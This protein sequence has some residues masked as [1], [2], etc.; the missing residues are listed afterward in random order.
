[1]SAVVYQFE[2]Q[3]P[4]AADTDPL[5]ILDIGS[6][7]VRLVV[8][9]GGNRVPT[10]L[11]NEKSLCGL[12]RGLASTGA[13][14]EPGIE[15]ALRALRRFRTLT[16]AMNVRVIYPVATAAVR[17]A[18]NGPDFLAAAEEILEVPVRLVSG[19][20]EAE[21]AALGV[22]SGIPDAEGVIG[23]LGGGS[24]ELLDV[25][26]GQLAD[27]IT[28]ELG[29]LRLMDL[30]F[31]RARAQVLESL[32]EI[33]W[34]KSFKGRP[35]YLV[36]G[37][38]RTLARVQ[39]A[40]TNYPIQVLH[41]FEMAP[42]EARQLAGT[43]AGMN[44][45]E[46][47]LINEISNR[48]IEALPYAALVLE[49]LITRTKPSRVVVSSYGLREGLHHLLLDKHLRAQDPLVAGTQRLAER[50]GR[51]LR[52]SEEVNAFIAPLFE[53]EKPRKNGGANR[54][55]TLRLAACYLA[56]LGR[57]LHPDDRATGAFNKILRAP[58][59]GIS[60]R[61]RAFLSLTMLNRYGGSSVS[62]QAS[63]AGDFLS[64][65]EKNEARLLGRSLRFGVSL[66]GGAEGL[67]PQIRIRRNAE[68]LSLLLPET[69]QP[70]LGEGVERRFRQLA[71]AAG[72]EARIE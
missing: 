7:S 69:L 40:Q 6:N 18:S 72:L 56:D 24:L 4:E 37:A 68:S 5:G 38:W 39:M 32:E 44:R 17:E 61:E 19:A 31:A 1:M 2:G 62:H 10:P 46:L 49:Q 71:N 15:C 14:Y 23:D 33:P 60:H 29:P 67:L 43:I 63:T 26:D 27:R 65:S 8:F 70:L 34:L 64:T 57:F 11:L 55:E 50:Y 25:R 53:G 58:L 9:E 30:G 66:C 45:R 59:S 36:G 48:R 3:G 52:L 28:R 21:L 41:H 47:E 51:S 42:E 12:G 16:R 22:L 20:E 13:L 35:F 54:A